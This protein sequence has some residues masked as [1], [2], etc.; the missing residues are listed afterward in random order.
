MSELIE[1]NNNV[2][3]M[4]SIIERVATS[5][6]ADVGKLE[7]MLELHE[8]V[9]RNQA[10]QQFDQ[11]M[12]AFQME[13]PVLEKSSLGHHNAR[14]AK[15]EYIQSR[16]DPVLR[17]HGLFIRWATQAC[18]DGKSRVT[19]ICSHVGGHS[20]E[21]SMEVAPDKGGSKSDIQSY[22]SAISYAQRYTMR[23]LL[24]LV[25]A[26]DNDGQVAI[27]ISPQQVTIIEKKLSQFGAEARGLMEAHIGCELHEIPK[28]D[29]DYWVGVLN[30]KLAKLEKGE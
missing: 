5:P 17:K 16:I 29:F 24:G 19:C 14:Y 3:P 7:K 2:D 25:I 22:G 11:A 26:E 15:L 18:A 6:D 8:R 28:N 9:Q 1:R 13:K 30:T 27:T 12:L 21:S 10:K 20:E 4:I 23:A